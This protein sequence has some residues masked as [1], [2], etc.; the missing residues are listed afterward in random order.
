MDRFDCIADY[1]PCYLSE[2]EKEKYIIFAKKLFISSY[3]VI[4]LDKLKRDTTLDIEEVKPYF[5]NRFGNEKERNY[6]DKEDDALLEY[7]PFNVLLNRIDVNDELYEQINIYV[8]LNIRENSYDLRKYILF[9]MAA[10]NRLIPESII[11]ALEET[12]AAGEY[13]N[14]RVNNEK[15]KEDYE[16]SSSKTSKGKLKNPSREGQEDNSIPLML[17]RTIENT[18]LF[19]GHDTLILHNISSDDPLCKWF[20]R[21]FCHDYMF[22]NIIYDRLYSEGKYD[23]L[24]RVIK[25][26]ETTLAFSKNKLYNN[27]YILSL[28]RLL[29]YDLW[30]KKDYVV[31]NNISLFKYVNED[32]M[33]FKMKE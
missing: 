28:P 10:Y 8:Y 19:I 13:Y 21:N 30:H 16:N 17:I 1:I 6:K 22:F 7:I 4:T 32:Y 14:A 18:P 33:D 29:F 27:L 11:E 3:F 2:K 20:I 25:I 26:V 9:T 15:I 23:D 31:R 24:N 12:G 5:V